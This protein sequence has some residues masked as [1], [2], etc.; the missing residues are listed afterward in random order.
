MAR[1]GHPERHLPPV[2]HVA[3][4]NG[5]GSTI[6]FLEAMARAAGH[7]VHTYTS[8][9]L[10]RFHERIRLGGVPIAEPALAALLAE[11]EAANG[12]APITFFEITTAAAFLAF[13]RTR[14]DLLLLET[15]LGG[16]LDATNLVARPALCAL[17]PIGMD[18]TQHLGETLAAIAGE[19][20]GILKAGV[21]A[22]V[23]AQRPEAAAAIAARADVVG[24]PLDLEG[25][26]WSWRAAKDG[27]AYREEDR[28]IALP[29]PALAGRHQYANAALAVACALRL[30][31]VLAIPEAAI[32]R[33]VAEAEWPARLQR[34]GPGPLTALLPEGWEIWLDGGHNADAGQALAD[35]F[36]DRRDD[37][38]DLVV[39]MFDTKDAGGFFRPFAGLVRS[40]RCVAIP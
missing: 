26:A 21:R 3:G 1:L 6:A 2:V 22:V 12:G 28:D 8:P 23:A 25:D 36:R 30:P 39:G 13:S 32:R 37:A 27:F 4:T 18:H 15:G 35:A 19:K 14:G 17:T 24:A 40:C 11:C 16:R 31:P 7:R 33:G 34:L 10:V 9:H 20:A 5:K 29:P 38:L